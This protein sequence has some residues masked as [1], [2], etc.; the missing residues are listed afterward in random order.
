MNMEVKHT[1]PGYE[2]PE[3]REERLRDIRRC[4]AA[5]IAALRDGQRGCSA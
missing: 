4:C 5:A 1:H 2:E 3:Q